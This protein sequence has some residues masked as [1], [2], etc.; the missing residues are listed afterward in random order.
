MSFLPRQTVWFYLRTLSLSNFIS[1]EPLNKQRFFDSGL[2]LKSNWHVVELIIVLN[3]S[4]DE[5]AK[6]YIIDFSTFY[7]LTDNKL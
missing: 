2:G 3:F 6:Y 1:F 4:S 5:E 7:D